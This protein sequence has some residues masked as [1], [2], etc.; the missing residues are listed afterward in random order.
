[1]YRLIK[2]QQVGT[3]IIVTYMNDEYKLITKKYPAN[4]IY[5]MQ[6]KDFSLTGSCSNHE[7]NN[8]EYYC[9]NL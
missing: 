5:P 8:Y 7:S 1:M 4:R 3:E 6:N 9:D 2:T